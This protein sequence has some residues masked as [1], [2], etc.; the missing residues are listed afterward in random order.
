MKKRRIFILLVVIMA[1]IITIRLPDVLRNGIRNVVNDSILPVQQLIVEMGDRI[2]ETANVIRGFRNIVSSNHEMAEELVYLRTRIRELSSLELENGELRRQL[3]YAARPG[4]VY[5]PCEVVG[6]D[7]GGWW[8]SIRI[9]CGFRDGVKI[10]QAV[11]TADGLVGRVESVTSRSADILLITDP[12]CKVSARISRTGTFGILE[13]DGASILGS[14][15]C[16]LSFLDKNV[17]II[18]GDEVVSSGL[19]GVFPKGV[20][21]GRVEKVFRDSMGLYQYAY[22]VPESELNK[23]SFLFVID[24]IPPVLQERGTSEDAD[25]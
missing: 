4:Y 7:V 22:V 1:G 6:R 10:G 14:P 24:S 11:M 21:I 2:H 25:Q 19:G 15:L 20:V 5:I 18:P 13:G 8:Q 3:G 9:N 16:K 12:A 23:L 17:S